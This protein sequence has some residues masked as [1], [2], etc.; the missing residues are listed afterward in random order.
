MATASTT[1]PGYV[2]K[3][4][5]CPECGKVLTFG[6]LGW[7]CEVWAHGGIVPHEEFRERI[8]Q[9]LC[10]HRPKRDFSLKDIINELKKCGGGGQWAFEQLIPT[11]RNCNARA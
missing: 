4:A 7:R 3:A 6:T 1:I 8:F 9:V 5:S 11:S 10:K 2:K